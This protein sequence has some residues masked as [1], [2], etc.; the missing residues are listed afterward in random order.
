MLNIRKYVIICVYIFYIVLN[1]PLS[2]EV[3]DGGVSDIQCRE[4]FYI[5]NDTKCLP[6]CHSWSSYSQVDITTSDVLIILSAVIGFSA[7]I[8]AIVLS[9]LCHRRM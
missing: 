6:S 1:N 7:S 4:G 2:M 9:C 3:K 8:L 5:V